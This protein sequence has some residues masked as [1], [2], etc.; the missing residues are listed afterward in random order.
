MFSDAFLIAHD[1]LQ[2]SRSQHRYGV[3]CMA[4]EL[5]W[6]QEGRESDFRAQT[7]KLGAQI[8]PRV[9]VPA[10]ADEVIE[11]VGRDFAVWLQR[12]LQSDCHGRLGNSDAALGIGLADNVNT[13][14]EVEYRHHLE[15]GLRPG[16]HYRRHVPTERTVRRRFLLLGR[17]PHA[18][19]KELDV[20]E[21]NNRTNS[22]SSLNV[23]RRLFH[24]TSRSAQCS[25]GAW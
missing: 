3:R 2:L 18:D 10:Y 13:H 14:S 15:V 23:K 6:K 9:H 25:N 21:R 5:N 17:I 11:F 1:G 7:L 12:I 4:R 24:A 22:H 19:L 20:R 8:W 16:R